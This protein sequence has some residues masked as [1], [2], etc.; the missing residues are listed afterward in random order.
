MK[1]A[2]LQEVDK[3]AAAILPRALPLDQD[4]PAA[5]FAK[6]LKRIGQLVWER[7]NLG[8]ARYEVQFESEVREEWPKVLESLL[9]GAG[10][11]VSCNV[12]QYGLATYI[13]RW[14]AIEPAV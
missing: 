14:Q 8:N 6:H 11:S 7:E 13:I 9:N 5:F 1:T 2:D 10:Y 12:N 3:L 4:N